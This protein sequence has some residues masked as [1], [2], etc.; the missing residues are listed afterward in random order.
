[1]RRVGQ[2]IKLATEFEFRAFLNWE[3]AEDRHIIVRQMRPAD[4]IAAGVA[5]RIWRGNCKCRRVE[6]LLAGTDA[7]QGRGR[8]Y[9]I[10]VVVIA[11]TV[12]RRGIGGDVD[13]SAGRKPVNT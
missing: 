4:D 11:G 7:A 3:V 13:G 12:A 10:G 1:M 5:E 9:D 6:P 2:V 8:V